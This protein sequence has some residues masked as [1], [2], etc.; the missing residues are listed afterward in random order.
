MNNYS[1]STQQ[2]T[3]NSETIHKRVS[4]VYHEWWFIQ[5]FTFNVL[6]ELVSSFI[7]ILNFL[8]HSKN[9]FR[10]KGVCSLNLHEIF[11][12]VTELILFSFSNKAFWGLPCILYNVILVA[13]ALFEF[14]P[15]LSFHSHLKFLEVFCA[16]FDFPFFTQLQFTCKIPAIITGNY[17]LCFDNKKFTNNQ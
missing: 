9:S 15:H 2:K 13:F 3:V 14:F 7:I 6:K 11:S 8:A 16:F 10:K 17:V 1:M 12:G 5:L 4:Y